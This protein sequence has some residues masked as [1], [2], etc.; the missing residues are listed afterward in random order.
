MITIKSTMGRFRDYVTYYDPHCVPRHPL[1]SVKFSPL[2][3]WEGHSEADRKLQQIVT[4]T[5]EATE[6]RVHLF[7]S[8]VGR[9]EQ[10]PRDQRDDFTELQYEFIINKI[11][12][13]K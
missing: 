7:V 6:G 2:I 9:L 1:I 13:L 11:E 3:E 10:I 8:A 4:G 5:E 12:N